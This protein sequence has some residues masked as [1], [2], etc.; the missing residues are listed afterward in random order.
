MGFTGLPSDLLR[1]F[2]AS[3]S[4][5]FEQGPTQLRLKYEDYPGLGRAS[6]EED[7]F[8]GKR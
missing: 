2:A 4:K 5:K 1:I 3:P 6:P 7:I 8:Q